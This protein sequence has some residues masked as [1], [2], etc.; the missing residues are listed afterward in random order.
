MKII[1][2]ILIALLAGIGA[3]SCKTKVKNVKLSRTDD[4]ALLFGFLNPDVD[5]ITIALSLA[6]GVSNHK[7]KVISLADLEQAEV[8]LEHKGQSINLSFLQIAENQGWGGD[9]RLVVFY[10]LRSQLP[11]LPGE[12]YSI[13]ARNKDLFDLKSITTVPAKE[14]DFDYEVTGP[15]NRPDGLAD[16]K[17]AVTVR[18]PGKG[19]SFMRTLTHVKDLYYAHNNFDEVSQPERESDGSIKFTCPYFRKVDYPDLELTLSV[20][21]ISESYYRYM[22]SVEKGDGESGNPF[23]EPTSMYTNIEGGY[24]VFAALCVKS[25]KI[26]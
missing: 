11:I 4:A 13:S 5:T 10:A 16:Y 26:E 6:K 25:K 17:L 3:M 2:I 18:D 22:K 15:F 20:S 9:N 1:K 7:E 14:F 12:T 24:G 23:A 8:K 21:N 19:I